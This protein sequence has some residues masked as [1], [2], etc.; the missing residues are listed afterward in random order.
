[1]LIHPYL[2]LL[3]CPLAIPQVP[4]GTQL[5]IR[6][7]TTIGSYASKVGT[8]VPAVLIAPV[9]VDGR[10]VLPAGS[11]IS[12][13]VKKVARVGLGIRHETAGLELGFDRLSLPG[14][15]YIPLSA[16]VSEVDNAIERVTRDGRIR[17]LRATDSGG[18]RV[19]GYIRMLLFRCELQSAIAVWL[20]RSVVVKVPE[21]ETY[22]PAGT[23][24]TL[25]LTEPLGPN[26]FFPGAPAGIELSQEDRGDLH[27][28]VAAM[29]D[30]TYAPDPDPHRPSDLTNVVL[31]G[32]H[33]QVA[34][35]FS[36]A[37]WTQALPTSLRRRVGWLRALGERRGFSAAPMTPLLL[38]DVEADMSWEKSLNNVSKRH[39]IRLWKQ[40]GDWK[41]RELWIGA[42][43]RDV[44]LAYLRPGHTFSHK[45]VAD[46]DQERDKVAYDLAF[47][48]C[49]SVMDWID[50][51]DV[52]DLT[53]NS[54]GDSMTTDKRLVAVQL[55]DCRAPRLST[56]TVDTEP[57]RVHGGKWEVFA[58]REILSARSDLLRDNWYW[59]GYETTRRIVQV[60]RVHVRSSS[61][62]GS[63]LGSFRPYSLSKPAVQAVS[64]T[65]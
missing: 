17:N 20:V 38:N 25:T 49:A 61:G 1:M 7:T 64:F 37:G 19:T 33:D 39:H 16:R 5:H 62:L 35:A 23:E 26:A 36:A 50:R 59:R 13:K 9:M 48:S 22:F 14:Q 65:Q 43:S 34:A 46:V 31:I 29:P 53:Q 60:V 12:G 41:G 18:T 54:T 44:N 11:T 3:M 8:P 2:L 28:L 4:S 40:P 57:V 42:A 21:P 52:P 58:R 27:R 56:G 47:T 10:T 45:I 24:F 63:F 32:S 30:R 55:N 15:A 6:L 51:P